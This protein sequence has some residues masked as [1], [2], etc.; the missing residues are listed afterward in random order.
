MLALTVGWGL[1][2][3]A[4]A[5]V[6]AVTACVAPSMPSRTARGS[7][8]TRQAHAFERYLRDVSG[9]EP[10]WPQGRER[11]LPSVYETYL[12]YAVALRLEEDWTR[13]FAGAFERGEL[14]Q[15]GWYLTPAHPGYPFLFTPAS[16]SSSLG[17][18]TTD[19]GT[20]SVALSTGSGGG[21]YSPSVGGGVSGGGGGSW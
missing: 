15:P 10:R 17:Q 1:V 4:V 16:F 3:L 14:S 21:S 18:V 12:P 5:L 7:E 6:G 11:L 2:G 19:L 9:D 20:S 8:L 13:V